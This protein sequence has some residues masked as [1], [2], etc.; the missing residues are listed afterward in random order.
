MLS[1]C[2]NLK[3]I[4]GNNKTMIKIK[5]IMIINIKKKAYC[6]KILFIIFSIFSKIYF[7]SN[8][9][10]DDI[11]KVKKNPITDGVIVNDP[12]S[13]GTSSKA[14]FKMNKLSKS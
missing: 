3:S 1:S 9:Y 8:P 6:I 12:I 14:P 4:T 10:I 13:G 11:T 5:V 2:I 7:F